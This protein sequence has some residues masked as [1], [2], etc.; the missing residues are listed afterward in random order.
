MQRASVASED[1]K[2]PSLRESPAADK[3]ALVVTVPLPQSA[4]DW[5]IFALGA[6]SAAMVVLLVF[7]LVK[8][9]A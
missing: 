6:G 1:P 8:L 3:A 5:A 4:R 9:L 2:G 7:L